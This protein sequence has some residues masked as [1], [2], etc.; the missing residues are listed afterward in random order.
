LDVLPEDSLGVLFVTDDRDLSEVYRLKL[1]LDGYSVRTVARDGAWL[2]EDEPWRPDVAYVDLGDSAD[3]ALASLER[4]VT[5][6]RLRD[7]PAIILTTQPAAVLRERGLHLRSIDYLVSVTR[8]ITLSRTVDEWAR[9]PLGAAS[10]P[11]R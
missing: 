4:L 11:G 5:D 6:A 7:V 10:R 2:A 9:S 8:P 1:E 3:A